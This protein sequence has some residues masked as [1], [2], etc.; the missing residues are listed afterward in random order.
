MRYIPPSPTTPLSFR[1]PVDQ[2]EV[3][4]EYAWRN[5]TNITMTMREFISIAL[6]VKNEEQ[7]AA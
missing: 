6:K 4:R 1:V 2:A 3:V 7:Q 5:K